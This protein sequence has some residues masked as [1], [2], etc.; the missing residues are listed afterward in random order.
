MMRTLVLL[1]CL[2]A[3]ALTAQHPSDTSDD[4]GTSTVPPASCT[5][6]CMVA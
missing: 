2:A 5:S 4:A 1:L 3:P 6:N